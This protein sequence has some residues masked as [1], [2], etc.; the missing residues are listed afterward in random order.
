MRTDSPHSPQAQKVTNILIIDDDVDSALM[1]ESVFSHLGCE[2]TC[3]LGCKEAR[4]KICSLQADL[5]IMDWMLDGQTEAS[6]VV[7]QCAE[8]FAKFGRGLGHGSWP[9]AKII[10]FSS[11]AASEIES[12]RNPYFEHLDHWQK[13][14]TQR[15]LLHRVLVL[16]GKMGC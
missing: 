3:S 1:V 11:L 6:S 9:K 12:L 15:E 5:I 16:L 7:R 14:I 13:P 8:T 2:T 10:T 4:E